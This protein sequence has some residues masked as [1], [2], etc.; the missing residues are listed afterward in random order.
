LIFSI[1]YFF[2][3]LSFGGYIY[4]Y[5]T[6][7]KVVNWLEFIGIGFLL[8]MIIVSI[9]NQILLEFLKIPVTTILI[10]DFVSFAFCLTILFFRKRNVKFN[11]G[12]QQFLV[13]IIF[14]VLIGGYH[15]LTFFRTSPKINNVFVEYPSDILQ[16]SIL[17][18]NLVEYGQSEYQILP[19]TRLNYYWLFFSHVGFISNLVGTDTIQLQAL[20]YP[21]IVWLIFA[22]SFVNFYYGLGGKRSTLL[23][24]FSSIL[25]SGAILSNN[26]ST[27]L[28]FISLTNILGVSVIL[29][30]LIATKY[31]LTQPNYF[32]FT[33][34][35]IYAVG[36]CLIKTPMLIPLLLAFTFTLIIGF[37]KKAN[38]V[39]PL[40]KLSMVLTT[41][42]LVTYFLLFSGQNQANAL[43]LGNGFSEVLFEAPYYELSS[44]NWLF[45]FTMFITGLIII[46]LKLP[47]LILTKKYVF[48]S[49]PL[50]LII[51]LN[52]IFGLILSAFLYH[53]GRS[54]FHFLV[55]GLVPITFFSSYFLAESFR[56]SK[57]VKSD[58]FRILSIFFVFT[59]W[60]PVM[61]YFS[62]KFSFFEV[63]LFRFFG[64]IAIL[65]YTI[66]IFRFDK[67]RIVKAL[68]CLSLFIGISFQFNLNSL[69]H[70]IYMNSITKGEAMGQVSYYDTANGVSMDH[71]TA[72]NWIRK[73]TSTSS[74]FLTNRFCI[75]QT[76]PPY[77]RPPFCQGDT[78]VL[79]A[80][81]KRKVYVEGYRAE[82]N[83]LDRIPSIISERVGESLQFIEDPNKELLNRLKV[84]GVNWIFVDKS[85]PYNNALSLFVDIKFENDNVI[86]FKF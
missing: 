24:G 35:C 86:I 81:S 66:I 68:F 64:P 51:Y 53:S 28:S 8:S 56:K 84:K 50:N 77:S 12:I 75:R 72:F 70:K 26:F 14:S 38:F 80:Y 43:H 58:M 44:I 49:N 42:F 25:I 23:I 2:L 3:F 61:F 63:V 74:I 31:F 13:P 71:L 40:F 76:K 41:L 22:V 32:Y 52:F 73:N 82:S 46:I 36:L 83:T 5:L 48:T 11:F 79:S 10:I 60:Y 21:L 62:Y 55:S 67:T 27:I 7:K 47:G 19:G 17:S 15:Y 16:F 34:F 4:L 1:A 78:F 33:Y 39:M 57:F 29:N 45:N 30:L 54:N 6:R 18:N 59:I 65:F 20:Y 9:F 37:L 69:P 85:F